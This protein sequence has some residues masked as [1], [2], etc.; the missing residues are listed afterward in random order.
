MVCTSRIRCVGNVVDIIQRARNEGGSLF[1][2]SYA[3]YLRFDLDV[4]QLWQFR[5][6]QRIAMRLLLGYGIPLGSTSSLPYI[7]QFFVG[8]PNSVRAFRIRSVGPG[9]YRSPNTDV[10]SFYDQAGDIRLEGNLE[11]RFP[12]SGYLKGAVFIDAGNVWLASENPDLP[13]SGFTS[14]FIEQLAVGSGF[15]LRFD[16]DF[17]VVRFD[18]AIPLRKPW[19]TEGSR[20]FD[21]SFP[22]GSSWSAEHLI[23]NFGIGYPF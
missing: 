20:W 13:G 10:Q 22:A 9:V 15:G 19:L 8:G 23:L 17:I 18:L 16:I 7:K 12:I 4:R 1:G 6:Q 14:R 3:H 11:Y 2:Q 21:Y 5:R